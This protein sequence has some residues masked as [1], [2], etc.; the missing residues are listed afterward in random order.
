MRGDAQQGM[1]TVADKL[2]VLASINNER[3]N[4][5]RLDGAY[6]PSFSTYDNNWQKS[7]TSRKKSG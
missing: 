6:T 5:D 2:G 1:E 4:I 3:V 7:L